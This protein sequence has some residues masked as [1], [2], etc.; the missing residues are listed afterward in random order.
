[1]AKHMF[2]HKSLC[3]KTSCWH[4]GNGF[5]S[6][7]NVLTVGSRNKISHTWYSSSVAKL[8]SANKIIQTFNIWYNS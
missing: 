5:T 4:A 1:M 3:T 6:N 2:V 7:L 8:P